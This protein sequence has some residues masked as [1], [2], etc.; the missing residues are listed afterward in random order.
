MNPGTITP[1]TVDAQGRIWRP[2]GTQV[3][4]PGLEPA[5]IL[6][7]LRDVEAG[8]VRPLAEIIAERDRKRVRG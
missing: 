8:R 6:A 2:D 4:C 7:G 3:V 1:V 5:N